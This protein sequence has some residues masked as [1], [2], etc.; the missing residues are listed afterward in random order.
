MLLMSS[1]T[2]DKVTFFCFFGGGLSFS[3]FFFLGGEGV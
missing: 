1:P 3:R 2:F